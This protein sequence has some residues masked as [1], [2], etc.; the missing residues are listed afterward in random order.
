M[1]L[2]L[3]AIQTESTWRL[4]GLSTDGPDTITVMQRASLDGI[5]YRAYVAQ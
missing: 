2:R 5:D 4:A 1:N 3:T